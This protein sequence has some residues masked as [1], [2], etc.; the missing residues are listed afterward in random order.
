M[1]FSLLPALAILRPIYVT[2]WSE[3]VRRLDMSLLPLRLWPAGRRGAGKEEQLSLNH[4]P[5]QLLPVL[6]QL[7][8]AGPAGD[9][10]LNNVLLRRR[11]GCY[12]ADCQ[13]I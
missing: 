12:V 4:M 6:P 1:V 9:L 10:N 11:L 7:A 8:L 3:N 5:W 13:C 2:L